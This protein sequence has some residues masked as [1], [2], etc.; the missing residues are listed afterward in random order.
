MTSAYLE[1]RVSKDSKAPGTSYIVPVKRENEKISS[2]V[3]TASYKTF[4][5]WEHSSL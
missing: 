4:L 1:F 3:K 5:F 2:F